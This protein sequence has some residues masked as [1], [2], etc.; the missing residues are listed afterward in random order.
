[1][2]PC[3]LPTKPVLNK[4]LRQAYCIEFKRQKG[5]SQS[6]GKPFHTQVVIQIRIV[7]IS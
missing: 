3:K 5:P 6:P 4:A 1:M 7:L 2:S